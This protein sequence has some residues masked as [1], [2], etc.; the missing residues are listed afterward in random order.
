MKLGMFQNILHVQRTLNPHRQPV[1]P[2][3]LLLEAGVPDLVISQGQR[4]IPHCSEN[5]DVQKNGA[6]AWQ[7]HS[8]APKPE[9]KQWCSSGFFSS[10]AIQGAPL[11]F[12]ECDVLPIAS[13]ISTLGPQL[14]VLFGRLRDVA[15]LEEVC[16]LWSGGMG[17]LWGVKDPC[18]SQFSLF[19]ALASRY[20][21]L[22]SAPVT[23]PAACFRAMM[24]SNH[25]EL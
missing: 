24:G 10:Y 12:F 11:W 25:L 3:Y 13:G 19:H 6:S 4:L 16:H 1:Q 14:M 17:R 8:I 23:I 2:C 15:L 20:E 7:E 18:H 21:P 5:W 9:R 22:A